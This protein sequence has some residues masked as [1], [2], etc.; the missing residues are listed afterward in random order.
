MMLLSCVHYS[1]LRRLRQTARD[2]LA[3]TVRW[4]TPEGSGPEPEKCMPMPILDV[5]IRIL[6][7]A[8]LGGVIG[9]EREIREHTA[10]FRTHILV[11]VGAAAFTL[12]SSYGIAGTGLDP[13]RIAAQIVSGIGFLG[14][15]AI[16][17]YG[18]SVRG[19]TTAASLW[20]VAAV[21]LTVG[22]G[23]Y[24]VAL[25]TTAVVIVSLYALRLIEERLLYPHV[26]RPVAVQVRFQSAGFSPLTQLI[27][28]LEQAHVIVQEMAVV[29]GESDADTIHLLLKL[30]RGIDTAKLTGLIAQLTDVRTVLLE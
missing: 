25:I 11:S 14:A 8:A 16:I 18:V 22:Q 1:S 2:A 5:V 9:I 26:G 23:F 21:G 6:L 7:A 15:G 13:N 10:G 3:D 19:L 27:S 20:T 29:P 24:S 17:R 12:A 28:A 30:P 4:R